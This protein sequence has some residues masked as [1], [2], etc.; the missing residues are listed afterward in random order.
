MSLFSPLVLNN[1]ATIPNRIAKAA[2][3]EN[4][5]DADHAPSAGLLRL[6]KAWAEGETGLIITGNVMV[7]ARAMTGHGGVVLEDDRHLDRFQAW[8]EAGRTRGRISGCRS[9]IR[10]GRCRPRLGRKR[11]PLPQLPLISARNRSG[12]RYRAK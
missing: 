7:D 12:F 2:M 6:Y 9:T 5:A 4:M 8:A 1:G 10:A 3:E 11:W